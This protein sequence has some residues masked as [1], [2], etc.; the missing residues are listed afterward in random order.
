MRLLVI[1]CR[2]FL[3]FMIMV[4]L[5]ALLS[6]A[7]AAT[8]DMEPIVSSVCVKTEEQ[9]VGWRPVEYQPSAPGTVPEMFEWEPI[10]TTELDLPPGWQLIQNRQ[11]GSFTLLPPGAVAPAVPLLPTGPEE[12]DPSTTP[13]PSGGL[14]FL[15]GVL[16]FFVSV[17]RLRRG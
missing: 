8:A 16:S 6:S 1:A 14:I 7:K 3:L 2:A 13:L 4:L 17:R 15:F 9:V 12:S 10:D 11:D 5:A